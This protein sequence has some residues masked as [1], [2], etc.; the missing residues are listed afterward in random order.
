M[1]VEGQIEGNYWHYI[2]IEEYFMFDRNGILPNTPD[3]NTD[4]SPSELYKEHPK[5]VRAFLISELSL[6][7]SYQ[8]NPMPYYLESMKL[9]HELSAHNER[10]RVLEDQGLIDKAKACYE[11]GIAMCSK[12]SNAYE[13]LRIIYT[14]EKKFDDAIRVCKAFVD[15]SNTFRKLDSSHRKSLGIVRTLRI[16]LLKLFAKIL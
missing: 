9:E 2:N 12:F 14:R 10:C 11:E 4:I 16:F 7:M 15:M 3:D 5:G 1:L 6:K 8:D 13:R